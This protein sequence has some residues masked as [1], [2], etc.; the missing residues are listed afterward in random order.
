MIEEWQSLSMV[1][2]A[3]SLHPAAQA[4]LDD[5]GASDLEQTCGL[6]RTAL[7]KVGCRPTR[8]MT[9]S[10]TRILPQQQV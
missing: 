6:I 8:N 5:S 9:C 10:G 2:M 7:P 4:T 1:C 3:G